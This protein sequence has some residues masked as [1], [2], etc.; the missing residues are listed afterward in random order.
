MISSFG[1]WLTR[2]LLSNPDH[3]EEFIDEINFREL[4]EKIQRLTLKR[5][6]DK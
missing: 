5:R 1:K 2:T 6:R 4:T 3:A